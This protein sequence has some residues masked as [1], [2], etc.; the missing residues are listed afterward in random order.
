MAWQAI[1]R[2]KS[3]HTR[4]Q[5]RL[6]FEEQTVILTTIYV[7]STDKYSWLD[8]FNGFLVF[9]LLCE[10]V[11]CNQKERRKDNE[12]RELILREERISPAM[13]LRQAGNFWE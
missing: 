1:H 5:K 11:N 12:A 9:Y 2:H 7:Y 10:R 4:T 13:F 3:K 8:E 6:I